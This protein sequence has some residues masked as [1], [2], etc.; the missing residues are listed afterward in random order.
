MIPLATTDSNI[1]QNAMIDFG[2]PLEK[3]TLGN[4]TNSVKINITI[5]LTLANINHTLRS[6]ILQNSCNGSWSIPAAIKLA[7]NIIHKGSH[8][9]IYGFD[10]YAGRQYAMRIATK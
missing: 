1:S 10:V 4:N 3:L 8:R 9:I 2:S 5:W 7:E 6:F